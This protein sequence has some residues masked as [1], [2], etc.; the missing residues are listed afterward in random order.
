[1]DNLMTLSLEAHSNEQNHHR[2]YQL[3]IG[4]DLLDDW[5]LIVRYGRVG[6]SGQEK[7]YA[8]EHS[9]EIQAMINDRLRRRL[10]APKRIHCSYR[11]VS[12]NSVAGFDTQE[13]LPNELMARFF[14]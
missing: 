5:T 8:S 11:V 9:K 1:M 6:Q 14:R 4:R 13:W 12:L 3:T 10:S 7:F 2:H